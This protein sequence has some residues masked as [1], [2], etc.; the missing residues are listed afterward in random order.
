MLVGLQRSKGLGLVGSRLG[1]GSS[2]FSL[3]FGRG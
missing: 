3:E 1:A 2:S